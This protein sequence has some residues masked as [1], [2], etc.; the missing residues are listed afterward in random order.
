MGILCYI[1]RVE[2]Y[3]EFPCVAFELIGEKRGSVEDMVLSND[4]C[5]M[6]WL[7]DCVYCRFSVGGMDT[8]VK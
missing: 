7:S 8:S 4:E 1:G 5:D 2:V 3:I 6:W